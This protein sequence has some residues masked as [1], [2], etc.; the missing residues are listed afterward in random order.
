MIMEDFMELK[1]FNCRNEIRNK[2]IGHKLGQFGY[3]YYYI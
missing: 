3:E 2:T 1:Q